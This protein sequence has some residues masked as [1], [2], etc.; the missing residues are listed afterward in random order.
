MKGYP[1][2]IARVG[3]AAAAWA[4]WL[5]SSGAGSSVRTWASPSSRTSNTSGA[6]ISHDPLPMHLS[7]ITVTFTGSDPIGLGV[8]RSGA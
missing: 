8:Q 7:A 2:R 4:T 3:Q 5:A 6:S 1:A